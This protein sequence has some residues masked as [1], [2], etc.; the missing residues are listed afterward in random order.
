[1]K[2]ILFDL[3]VL[4]LMVLVG[5][6]FVAAEY[7]LL[8]VKKSSLEELARKGDRRAQAALGMLASPEGFLSTVQVGITLVGILSGAFGGSA[9]SQPLGGLLTRAGV[10]AAIATE[11]AVALV[12]VAITYLTLLLGELIPKQ[13][14]QSYTVAMTLAVARPMSA[15]AKLARPASLLL[16]KSSALLLGMFGLR[17]Q[18][19]KQMTEEELRHVIRE[20]GTSGVLQKTETSIVER[21]IGLGDRPSTAFM[22]PRPEL[23]FFT[24]DAA[25]ESVVAKL[26]AEPEPWYLVCGRELDQVR[27]VVRAEKLWA[28]YAAGG[29]SALRLSDLMEPPLLV[30]ETTTG[31]ETLERLL[32]TGN[33]VAILLDEFGNVAGALALDDYVSEIFFGVAKAGLGDEELAVERE[34]GSWLVAGSMTMLEFQRRFWSD[35]ERETEELATKYETVAGLV[36]G[37]L[38]HLPKVAEKLTCVGLRIEVVDLDGRRVD[39]V[40]VVKTARG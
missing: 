5:A 16:A 20:A 24:L 31:L 29:A 23:R 17:S 39:K 30:P 25:G 28:A 15:F 33:R 12:V 26:R 21:T 40:L 2:P 27:G 9:F 32:T 10:P 13:L 11:L 22:K 34:D 7:A 6:V 37:E 38:G 36:I 18:A 1:M 35:A 3:L 4:T 8:L 14:A 19:D